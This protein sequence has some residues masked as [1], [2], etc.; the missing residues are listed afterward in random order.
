MFRKWLGWGQEGEELETQGAGGGEG[1]DRD[2][3][4]GRQSLTN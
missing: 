4:A 1:P 2:G 3:R